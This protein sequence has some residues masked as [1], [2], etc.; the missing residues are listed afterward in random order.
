MD[1]AE[2]QKEIARDWTQFL[3]AAEGWCATHRCRAVAAVSFR[4]ACM[5]SPGRTDKVSLALE[6]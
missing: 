1:L 6:D 5:T 4:Q 3:D 2:A